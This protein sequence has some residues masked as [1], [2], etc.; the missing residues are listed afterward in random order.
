M[1]GKERRRKGKG[2]GKNRTASNKL[3]ELLVLVALLE[4]AI[5]VP[6]HHGVHMNLSFIKSV[7]G[8]TEGWPRDAI[9]D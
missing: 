6:L 9:P 1:K 2:K 3:L 5:G 4:A 8:H 7:L